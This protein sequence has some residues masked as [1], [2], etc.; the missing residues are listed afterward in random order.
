MLGHM[1]PND[2]IGWLDI[3]GHLW[4]WAAWAMPVVAY[5][6]YRLIGWLKN[7]RKENGAALTK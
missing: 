5:Y 7:R 4:M 2:P 3:A 6:I 1:H